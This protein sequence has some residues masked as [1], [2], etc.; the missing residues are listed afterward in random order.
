VTSCIPVITN[1]N[2]PANVELIEDDELGESFFTISSI[3]HGF[4]ETFVLTMQD[5]FNT[6]QIPITFRAC[7]SAFNEVQTL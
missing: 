5:E 1:Q 7:Q 6:L 3:A 2:S 4:E